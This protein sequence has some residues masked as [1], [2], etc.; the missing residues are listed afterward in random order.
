MVYIQGIGVDM[1][2][3][4]S[5]KYDLAIYEKYRKSLNIKIDDYVIISIG[6]FTKGKTFHI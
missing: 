4:D 1:E 2:K 5:K 6:E 3:F